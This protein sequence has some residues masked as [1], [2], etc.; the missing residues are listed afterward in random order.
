[1]A[2]KNWLSGWLKEANSEVPMINDTAVRIRAGIMLAIPLFMGFTLFQAIY[3]SSWV[4]T[5][6]SVIDTYETDMSGR[7]L[8][9]VEA[10]RQ[11]YDYSLQTIILFYG[12]FEMLV[13]MS[14]RTAILSPTIWISKFLARYRAPDWKL[15]APK[16][17]AW[18]FGA[19]M[20]SI[21]LVFFNPDTFAEWV[22]FVA[23]TDVLPTTVN[24][25]PS[26]IPNVLVITCISFM[27]MEAVL[28]FCAGCALYKVA[29]K[30]GWVV[31]PCEACNALDFRSS[32][33]S[34]T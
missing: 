17:F 13:G 34:D 32:K 5:G 20:I 28:G 7:I 6:N 11:T 18:S 26:W 24:Y 1:M 12:L 4:V 33:S 22:N 8:Y 31:E 23:R 2:D 21:C 16:R 25:M 29:V 19:F 9:Q 30:L 14:T 3:G 27:W 10:I 15:L